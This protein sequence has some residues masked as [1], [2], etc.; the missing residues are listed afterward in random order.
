M[1]E[2]LGKELEVFSGSDGPDIC[3]D[4][5]PRPHQKPVFNEI[6][7]P[8]GIGGGKSD[9]LAAE[10]HWKGV[11]ENPSPQISHSVTKKLDISVA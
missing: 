4:P 3:R 10:D 1:S 6:P 8:F 7:I 5:D 11:S 2:G 9:N